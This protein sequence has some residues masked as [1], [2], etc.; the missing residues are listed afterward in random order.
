LGEP[1]AIVVG[2]YVN[3][4]GFVRALA[5]R[6]VRISVVTTKPYDIAHRSRWASSHDAVPDIDDHPERLVEL[7]ERRAPEW[8]GAAVFPTNDG[9]LAALAEHHE[10]LSSAYRII[11]PPKEIARNFLDKER[12]GEV[13]RAVGLDV[14]RCYGPANEATAARTDLVF[15]VLVKPNSGHRF[16]SRFGCKLFSASDRDEL[17]SA[18]AILAAAGLEGRIVDFVPGADDSI[19]AYCTYIDARGEPRGGVTVRKLRQSPP[20][21]GVARVAEIARHDERLRE[22][23][24]AMVRRT[25]FRGIATA[26]FKLDPRDGC[27]RFIEM[28]ARSIVYNS[29]LRKVGLDTAGLAWSEHVTGRAEPTVANDWRG[30]W[31]HLHADLLYSLFYRRHEPIPLGEFWAP[32]RRPRVFAVWSA[33]DPRPFVSQ[34]SRTAWNGVSALARGTGHELFKDR[35][36]PTT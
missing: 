5:A 34:W 33:T 29:L 3:G 27:H 21:F 30:V 32:Y 6:D 18:V 10:R 16:F 23:T 14:P 22:A 19:F 1:H 2:G 35:A 13:A 28:N 17:V 26:E 7:L 4:L 8:M 15:P 31:I 9:A 20:F 24:L 36:H 25:G 12:M 11:A